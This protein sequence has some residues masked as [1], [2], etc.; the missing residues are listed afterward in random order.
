MHVSLE[1]NTLLLPPQ[2]ARKIGFSAALVLQQMH[3]WLGKSKHLINGVRW[4]YNSFPAWAEQLPL[5]VRTIKRA[6]A[7][8]RELN[9]IQVERHG[10]QQW[11]QTN[12]YTINYQELEALIPPIVPDCPDQSGQPDTP[13]EDSLAPSFS[14]ITPKTFSEKRERPVK[15][16]ERVEREEWFSLAH[17]AQVVAA[18]QDRNTVITGLNYELG[19]GCYKDWKELAK[20]YPL[21]KL[22]QMCRKL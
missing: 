6:I 22:D 20:K 2:L 13:N 12:W 4:I 21:S 8:L 16:Q 17:L 15:Q 14:E 10:K 11:D 18:Q 7:K 19:G 9:L 1:S 3:Y 5:A